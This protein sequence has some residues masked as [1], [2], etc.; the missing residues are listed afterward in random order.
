MYDYLIGKNLI[1]VKEE[2]KNQN[3]N[4]IIKDNNSGSGHFDTQ[5]VVRVKQI[6]KN[7]LELIT[8]KFLITI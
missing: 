4:L 5:L 6:D 3:L 7:T 1:E 2:L 8:S